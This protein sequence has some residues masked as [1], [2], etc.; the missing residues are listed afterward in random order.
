M[1]TAAC[2]NPATGFAWAYRREVRGSSQQAY[3]STRCAETAVAWISR[4]VGAPAQWTALED[5]DLRR[6]GGSP[7]PAITAG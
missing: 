5:T 2:T 4:Y 6:A 1:G 7:H 3:A